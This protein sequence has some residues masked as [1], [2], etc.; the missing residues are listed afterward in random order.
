M[1]DN[2]VVWQAPTMGGT[3]RP[4]PGRGRFLDMQLSPD[5]S[6]LLFMENSPGDPI[7][8]GDA[9]GNDAKQIHVARRAG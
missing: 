2:G 1:P 9:Q 6:K 5:R 8:I 3:L 7:F 4:F